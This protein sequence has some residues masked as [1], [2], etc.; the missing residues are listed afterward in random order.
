[1]GLTVEGLAVDLPKMVEWKDGIVE[2]LTGGV[3]FLC[4]KNGVEVVH[5]AADFLSDRSLAVA[6]DD[7]PVEIEFEQAVIATGSRPCSCRSFPSTARRVIGSTEAL[8]SAGGARPA[9]GHRRRLHRSRARHGLR[10]ARLR[11][12]GRRVPAGD[13][14]GSR[15]RGRQGPDQRR[16]KKLKIKLLLEPPRRVLRAR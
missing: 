2:R 1:M 16:L 14:A 7:G 15:P 6:T 3:E 8:S 12:D 5:G 11:G 4:K 9:G 10:Q 13:H